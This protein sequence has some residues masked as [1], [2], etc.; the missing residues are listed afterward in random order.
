MASISFVEGKWRALIRRRGHKDV[1][2]RFDTKGEAAAWARDIEG[3]IIAGSIAP[4]VASADTVG[5]LIT[6]Y[7]ALR[8]KTRPISDSANEHFTLKQLAR[9]LGHLVAAQLT[10]DDPVADR[11]HDD[12]LPGWPYASVGPYRQSPEIRGPKPEYRCGAAAAADGAGGGSVHAAHG[13]IVLRMRV[14]RCTN[15]R[16]ARFTTVPTTSTTT[17]TRPM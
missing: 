6:R 12:A 9:D 17:G 10:A 5:Q 7:R 14:Q 13:L 4:T 2:K 16:T 1:S 8:S 11:S 3:R 15:E